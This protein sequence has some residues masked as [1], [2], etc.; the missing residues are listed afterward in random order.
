MTVARARSTQHPGVP[1][2][3]ALAFVGRMATQGLDGLPAVAV[4]GGLGYGSIRT[5]A[6]SARLSAARQFG[7]LAR[8]GDSCRLTELGRALAAAPDRA[9]LLRQALAS[10]PLYAALIER[11]AGQRMPDPRALADLL[12]HRHGLTP[13]AKA[14]AAAAFLASA[15][16]AGALGSDEILLAEPVAPIPDF[17]AIRDPKSSIESVQFELQL[18]GADR[19]K[20]VRVTAPESLTVESLDR[21]IAALRLHVRIVDDP[22]S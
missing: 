6:F 7:L 3:E 14:A 21:L 19:G 11:L 22:A 20:V 8:D 17:S 5:N 1:L 9:D 18:W 16:L 2:G 15:R 12:Q 13:R 10:P 4:A